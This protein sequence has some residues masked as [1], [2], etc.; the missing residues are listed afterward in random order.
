M[1]KLAALAAKRR[2]KENEK[3]VST[4]T[5]TPAGE[6]PSGTGAYK[7]SL[8]RLRSKDYST[9]ASELA[10]SKHSLSSCGKSQTTA[11]P[12]TITSNDVESGSSVTVILGTEGLSSSQSSAPPE[13]SANKHETEP[14]TPTGGGFSFEDAS[15]LAV[16]SLQRRPSAFA[17]TVMGDGVAESSF[18]H[19][20]QH[21]AD[22]KFYIYGLES[23][24]TNKFD[25]S[26]PSPDDVVLN[27]QKGMLYF[28]E[29]F[30]H[31]TSKGTKLGKF[32][33]KHA[34]GEQAKTELVDGVK[35]LSVSEVTS[36]QIVQ[37]KNLDV[38][39][40]YKKAKR[41]NA[42]NFVVI[43]RS[44]CVWMRS[45]SRVVSPSRTLSA[46]FGSTI[47]RKFADEIHRPRRRG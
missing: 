25:F 17:R 9:R 5:S 35:D 36:A 19:G 11:E 45:L 24:N 26:D 47:K 39:A 20:S 34:A 1:S 41:K 21:D 27:A 30:R 44:P 7:S 8:D 29:C 33:P 32:G 12:T 14:A 16:P 28:K 40:E 31:L 22:W 4:S 46:S 2:Q 43:G 13:E 10:K 42:A 3:I 37:N 18:A 23:N 15:Q 38:I 6:T